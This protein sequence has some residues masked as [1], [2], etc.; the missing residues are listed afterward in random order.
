MIYAKNKTANVRRSANVNS[1]IIG[2]VTESNGLEKVGITS[3]IDGHWWYK[4][5]V[6]GMTG[7]IRED[8]AIERTNTYYKYKDVIINGYHYPDEQIKKKLKV[9]LNGYIQ[10][11]YLPILERIDAPKGLKLLATV[12]TAQEGF[13]KGTRSYKTNNPANIGNVDNGRNNGFNSLLDGITA[14]L[15]YLKRVANGEHSAYRFGNKTIKPY[16][17]E[18]IKNNPKTYGWKSPYLPGYNFD[19]K[20]QLGA[21]VKIYSTGARFGN[22]YLSRI[23]SYFAQNG[24]V[25]T[26]NSLLKD[27]V[28]LN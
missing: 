2:K 13:Y 21:F 19:Y 26:E 5:E 27:I 10:N 11:E 15:N 23:I 28:E 12:M 24:Y 4:V 20:G 6:N 16:F 17:S 14:Q 18:E 1:S 8:V 3:V 22:G 25:I 7:Y 9:P